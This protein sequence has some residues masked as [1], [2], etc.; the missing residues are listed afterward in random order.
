MQGLATYL[1]EIH[2]GGHISSRTAN[3]AKRVWAE[4]NL[5]THARLPVPNASPGPDGMLLLT[6]DRHEH[7]LEL[8][9]LPEKSPSFF[10]FDR[11]KPGGWE[12]AYSEYSGA[13]SM[14]ERLFSVFSLFF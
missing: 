12:V 4:L 2:A 7:H 14:R 5:A 1:N 10:Y 9:F 13:P 8:E 3:D 11:L 6:W